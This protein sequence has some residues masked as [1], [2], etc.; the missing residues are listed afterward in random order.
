MSSVPR[1]LRLARSAGCMP[2]RRRRK[3]L[4]V[5][6]ATVAPE[7]RLFAVAH[8]RLYWLTSLAF[9]IARARIQCRALARLDFFA[10]GLIRYRTITWVKALPALALD[11]DLDQPL[12]TRPERSGIS[13]KPQLMLLLLWHRAEHST[14][15]RERIGTLD[16]EVM[17]VRICMRGHHDELLQQ[18]VT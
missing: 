12:T 15:W 11:V 17:R 2:V 9:D 13:V 6:I 7:R 4:A 16:H 5:Y 1:Y 10:V 8:S 3:Q 14:I 18:S